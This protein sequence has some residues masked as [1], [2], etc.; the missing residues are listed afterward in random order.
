M[1]FPGFCG[2]SYT[3]ESSLVDCESLINLYTEIVESGQGRN[4]DRLAMYPTPGASL[5]V[6]LR[7]VGSSIRAL[8]TSPGKRS[9]AIVGT[10]LHELSSTRTSTN[11]G[12]ITT[13]TVP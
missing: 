1:N 2:P 4:P 7:S 6:D 13:E 8:H 11:R 5:F 9:F 3:S 10:K 12:T